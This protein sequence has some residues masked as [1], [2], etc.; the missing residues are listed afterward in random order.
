MSKSHEINLAR[1]DMS[2]GKC[3]ESFSRDGSI[4]PRAQGGCNP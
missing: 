3:H 4:A 1:G 2:G